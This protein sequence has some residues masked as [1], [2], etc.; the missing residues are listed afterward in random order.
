MSMSAPA[1]VGPPTRAREGADGA[2]HPDGEGDG[3]VRELVQRL[4]ADGFDGFFSLEPH[5]GEYTA[6]GALSGAE[7]WTRAHTAFTTILQDE[8]VQYA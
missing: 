4:R 5:L 3:Q 6:L 8:G 7:Q 1:R 2:V